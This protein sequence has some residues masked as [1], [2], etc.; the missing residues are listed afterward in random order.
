[1]KT[2]WDIVG[3]GGS[4]V[5]AQVEAQTA[6]L[7]GRMAHVRRKVAVVSGKGGVGK[8]TVTANLAVALAMDGLRMKIE[9]ARTISVHI[10]EAGKLI[11]D[12]TSDGG[13]RHGVVCEHRVPR[14]LLR[15]KPPR[16]SG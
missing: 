4:N 9:N 6:R 5:A 13:S 12:E 15:H 1:M 16:Q 2:Y 8:S 7:R 10:D 11:Q 3:D 14:P